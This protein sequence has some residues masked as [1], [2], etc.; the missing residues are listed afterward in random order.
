MSHAEAY[1]RPILATEADHRR[2]DRD[3]G[4]DGW[5]M[6]FQRFC[7]DRASRL[8]S[9][10]HPVVGF[11]SDASRRPPSKPLRSS[12]SPLSARDAHLP[13]P[14]SRRRR[15]RRRLR[16]ARVLRPRRVRGPPSARERV[17]AIRDSHPPRRRPGPRLR[18]EPIR[19]GGDPPGDD[20]RPDHRA[21][22]RAEG[23]ANGGE[24]SGRGRGE[25]SARARGGRRR[26]EGRPRRAVL[27]PEYY[28]RRRRRRRRARARAR[29]DA[30]ARRGDGPVGLE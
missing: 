29:G 14:R 26:R 4:G 27:P 18:H 17:D 5:D 16:V 22:G 12:P 2:R 25:G 21:S 13:P 10:V 15:P 1:S 23:G 30:A 11:S 3:D 8:G 9:R 24:G 7:E 28:A 19:P 6:A 20:G